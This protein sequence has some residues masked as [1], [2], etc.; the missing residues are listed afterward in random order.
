MLFSFCLPQPLRAARRRR[1]APLALEALEPRWL[2]AN[3]FTEFPIPTSG[4][5]PL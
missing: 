4:G 5:D 2:L 1:A 3:G